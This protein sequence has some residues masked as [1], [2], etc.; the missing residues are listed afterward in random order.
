M[1][2]RRGVVML[3]TIVATV[4]TNREKRGFISD[5]QDEVREVRVLDA[6]IEEEVELHQRGYRRLLAAVLCGRLQ[7]A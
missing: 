1:V 6:V 5:A 3:T 7:E 4:H 2:E